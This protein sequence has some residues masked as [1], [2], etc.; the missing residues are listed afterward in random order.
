MFQTFSNAQLMVVYLGSKTLLEKL[1]TDDIFDLLST[2]SKELKERNHTNFR[3][4]Y[5]FSER[6]NYNQF[7]IQVYE[8]RGAAMSF[9]R[10]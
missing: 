2:L 3:G 6:T 1:P 9:S 10:N 7:V 8:N 5:D 4:W